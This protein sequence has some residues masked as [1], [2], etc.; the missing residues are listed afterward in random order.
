M[1]IKKNI[2]SWKD[3]EHQFAER[4]SYLESPYEQIRGKE[5][6][7]GIKDGESSSGREVNVIVRPFEEMMKMTVPT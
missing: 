4:Y 5:A 1:Q 2:S 6:G 7:R 3:S